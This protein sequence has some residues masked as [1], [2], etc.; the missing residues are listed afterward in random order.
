MLI[1]LLKAFL[2]SI[3]L[4][5][6]EPNKISGEPCR[7]WQPVQALRPQVPDVRRLLSEQA[8]VRIHRFRVYRQLFRGENRTFDLHRLSWLWL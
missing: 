5:L 3:Q 1:S 7:A 2:D 8:K 4:L 6:E